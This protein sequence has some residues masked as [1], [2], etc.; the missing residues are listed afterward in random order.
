MRTKISTNNPH[1]HDRYGFAW[2]QVGPNTEAHLDF[3]CYG[4]KF[5]D[6]LRAKGIKRLVGLDAS[7]EAIEKGRR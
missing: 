1:G 3:G 6:S 7:G 4:G 5:L 2:E